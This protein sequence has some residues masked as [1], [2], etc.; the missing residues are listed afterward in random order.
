MNK[1]MS[2][3]GG[4][5]TGIIVTFVFLYGFAQCQSADDT[6][7]FKKPGEI[8]EGKAFQ[9]FQVLDDN[10]ALVKG[11]SSQNFFFG[12]VYLIVNEEGKY[13]YDE[14]IIKVPENKV[15]RQI[16]IYRYE[17]K[18]EFEKAVPIIQI[19]DN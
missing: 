11:E 12:P 10:A 1:W 5:L 19:L 15:V 7:M 14:E 17:T 6:T 2:F 8:I 13:Y 9:V 4:V 3:C 16:G 18:S